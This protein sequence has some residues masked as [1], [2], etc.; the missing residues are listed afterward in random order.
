[1]IIAYISTIVFFFLSS[2]IPSKEKHSNPLG[3]NFLPL[4][5]ILLTA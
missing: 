5:R 2:N 1:L 3:L 4:F